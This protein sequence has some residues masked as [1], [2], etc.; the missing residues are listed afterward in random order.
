[1]RCKKANAVWANRAKQQE[2]ELTLPCDGNYKQKK[3]NVERGFKVPEKPIA[4]LSFSTQAS[5]HSHHLHQN[6]KQVIRLLS[7]GQLGGFGS[8]GHAPA[9]LLKWPWREKTLLAQ[10]L[11]IVNFD[12]GL[13]HAHLDLNQNVRVSIIIVILITTKRSQNTG[14]KEQ[15]K[16]GEKAIA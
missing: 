14:M 15:K 4:R 7:A 11:F 10:H 3:C 12:V 5:F 9:L 8:Q 13:H 6:G 1:M 16:K 2:R